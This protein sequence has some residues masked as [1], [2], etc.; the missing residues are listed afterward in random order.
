MRK[1][2]T[3]A[4]VMSTLAVFLVLGGGA[5]FA[6]GQLAKNSVGTRQ[7]KP[8]AV[9]AAKLKR[10]AVTA[11]KLANGA[12]TGGKL[13]DGAAT[14]AKL[15]NG[16]VTT[17]KLANGAI[18]GAK[19]QA[20]GLGTVPSATS[21]TNALNAVN[22]ANLAGQQS[23]FVRLNPGQEQ[24]IAANGS[25]ALV[26]E[27]ASGVGGSDDRVRILAQS[28]LEGAILAGSDDLTGPGGNG[29]YLGP[30]TPADERELVAFQDGGGEVDVGS[31]I[32]QGYVLGPDDR[33]IAVN[34]EGIAL[35]LNYGS[36][37]CLAAGVVNLIG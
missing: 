26:A 34:S 20:A 2:L 14:T 30:A 17:A 27:C 31:V 15:A 3:Y 28:S 35:G 4:N 16:A 9:T 7:L 22:A 5:A 12:V 18:T 36:S 32:D 10:S 29:K 11:A 6:A 1:R 24:T 8:N 19:V 21:A 33:M 25:V 13:A 23:F 37:V